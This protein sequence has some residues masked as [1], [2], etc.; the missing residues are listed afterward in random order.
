MMITRR[1]VRSEF[2]YK[3]KIDFF[4]STAKKDAFVAIC[5]CNDLVL[6]TTEINGKRYE[7]LVVVK[8]LKT[9]TVDQVLKNAVDKTTESISKWL[10]ANAN[11]QDF[12]NHGIKTGKTIDGCSLGSYFEYCSDF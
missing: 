9:K 2:F 11:G 5:G 6:V 8:Q 7:K 10:G 12:Y 3:N 4:D 1:A